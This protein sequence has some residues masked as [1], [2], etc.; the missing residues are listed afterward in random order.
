MSISDADL[1]G[2]YI[3]PQMSIASMSSSHSS[4][5]IWEENT[6]NSSNKYQRWD[7]PFEGSDATNGSFKFL[8]GPSTDQ[9]MMWAPEEILAEPFDLSSIENTQMVL[10]DVLGS[11]QMAPIS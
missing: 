6:D 7:T 5:R 9:N 4:K 2:A 1:N 10:P 11:P 8:H 3:S